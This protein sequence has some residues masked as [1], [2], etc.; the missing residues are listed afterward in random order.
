LTAVI[1]CASV[2]FIRIFP[3]SLTISPVLI[4]YHSPSFSTPSID[5]FDRPSSS[6]YISLYSPSLFF[7][8]HFFR[9]RRRSKLSRPP[10]PA[11]G[12]AFPGISDLWGFITVNEEPLEVHGIQRLGSKNVGYVE[13]VSG[14]EFKV[15]F[16]DERT[17]CTNGKSFEV[18]LWADGEM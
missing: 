8:L 3:V 15:H 4:S 2:S 7:L 14:A 6:T 16:R 17:K 9:R 12:S 1:D 18:S 11:A 10:S 5:A 13:A